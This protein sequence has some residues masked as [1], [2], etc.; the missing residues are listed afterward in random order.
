MTL[1]HICSCCDCW[2]C[3]VMTWPQRY[4]SAAVMRD[5]NRM[6][7]SNHHSSHPQENGAKTLSHHPFIK[8]RRFRP[9]YFLDVPVLRPKTS[10]NGLPSHPTTTI[11]LVSP[12]TY[13]FLPVFL[14]ENTFTPSIPLLTYL[15]NI[16][17]RKYINT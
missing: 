3:D 1:K 4:A 7:H 8:S 5:M 13:L 2:R 11:R 12:T 16:S 17:Y 9:F 6:S 15:L 14:I 10:L